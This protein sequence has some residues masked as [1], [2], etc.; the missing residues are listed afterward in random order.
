MLSTERLNLYFLLFHRIILWA[1]NPLHR[2]YMLHKPM[3]IS[4]LYTMQRIE[5]GETEK[6][7]AQTAELILW[8]KMPPF[9]KSLLFSRIQKSRSQ[10]HQGLSKKFLHVTT[11]TFTKPKKARMDT[12]VRLM[13]NRSV[14]EVQQRL[15]HSDLNH[16]KTDRTDTRPSRSLSLEKN[17]LVETKCFYKDGLEC[18]PKVLMTDSTHELLRN[19]HA[20][21]ETRYIIQPFY[22]KS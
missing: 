22:L 13:G 11:K 2:Q 19:A 4:T 6:K 20:C 14:E 8:I 18:F 1:R 12:T 9:A 3:S 17:C 15:N 10:I 7:R 5:D 21:L 16:C